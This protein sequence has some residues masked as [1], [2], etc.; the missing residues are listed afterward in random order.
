MQTSLLARFET[1][2]AV[3]DTS[4]SVEKLRKSYRVY[5]EERTL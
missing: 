1:S 2:P 5:Y 3:R 4:D